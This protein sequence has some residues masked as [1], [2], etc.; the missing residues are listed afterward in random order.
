MFSPRLVHGVYPALT[1]RWAKSG[2]GPHVWAKQPVDSRTCAY[3]PAAEVSAAF[4]V[5]GARPLLARALLTSWTT[6]SSGEPEGVGE[7]VG[8]VVGT[9]TG[10]GV[11]GG[12]DVG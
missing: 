4:T 7:A 3:E 2:T 1:S 11:A 8:A 5:S 10:V 9:I 6:R 12:T